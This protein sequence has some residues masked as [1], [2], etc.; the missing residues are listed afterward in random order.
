MEIFLRASD[1]FHFAIRIEEDGEIF[2]R[3][4]AA[5]TGDKAVKKLFEDL[6]NAEVGHK[7]TFQNMLTKIGDHTP[8]ESY[9]GEYLAY[10]RD[11]IDN[12]IVFTKDAKAR[13][14]SDAYDMLS[15]LDF[16]IQRELDSILYYQEMKHFLPE[17]QHKEIDRIIGEERKHFAILAEMKGR[18]K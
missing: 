15:A 3:N 17:K 12:K 11:Y 14:A 6:A 10:L 18:Y 8:P 7:E 1:I 2:Y 9:S 5:A 13:L 4:A 16:A